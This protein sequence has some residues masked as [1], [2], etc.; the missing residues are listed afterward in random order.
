MQWGHT[1]IYPNQYIILIGP[2]GARKAEPLNIAKSFLKEVSID[3]VAESITRE[4]LIRRMK[5]S[6]TNFEKPYGD[7]REVEFQSAVTCIL[8]ELAVFLEAEGKFLA[9]LTN[10]YDCQDKWT[11]E[12]KHS[13][14]DEVTGVCVNIIGSMAPDWIPITLPS[15]A[16]G[17]GFTSR[18]IFVVE[19][20]KGATITNPNLYA[21]DQKV[22]KALVTDLQDI[23]QL[24]GEMIFSPEALEMYEEWYGKEDQR[25]ARGHPPIRDSRFAGY[26]SRRATHIKKISI[27]ISAARSSSLIITGKDFQRARL[28]LEQVEVNMGETFERVGRSQYAEQTEMVL[29]FIRAKG[30]TSRQEVMREFYRDVDGKGIEIIEATLKAAGFIKIKPNFET[31]TV[32]YKWVEEPSNN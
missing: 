8:E 1:E 14:V 21:Q 7:R 31:S 3:S 29:K 15:S 17:G 5:N 12:T 16:I 13:G 22:W 26:T 28:F 27:A 18:I 9:N 32:S 10:W 20:R 6:L 24:C 11:Y 19:H 25:I 4:A 30:N 23:K 2:S